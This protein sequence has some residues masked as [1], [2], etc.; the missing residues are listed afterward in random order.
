MQQPVEGDEVEALAP[1]RPSV[2]DE[3]GELRSQVYATIR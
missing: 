3:A 1:V 2:V